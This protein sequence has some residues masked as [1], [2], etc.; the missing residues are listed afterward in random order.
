ME[1]MKVETPALEKASIKTSGAWRIAHHRLFHIS[2]EDADKVEVKGKGWTVWNLCFLEDLLQIINLTKGLLL[3]V[4]WYP[5]SDPSG[6]YRLLVIRVYGAG[7]RGRDSYDWQ[8]PV[9][10]FETRSLDELLAEVHRIVGEENNGHNLSSA[11]PPVF[12]P[13]CRA[14]HQMWVEGMQELTCQCCGLRVSR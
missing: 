3:D 5:D 11:L 1:L 10:N 7:R 14:V 13:H 9:F 2:P 6:R 12:C 4:G 8:N